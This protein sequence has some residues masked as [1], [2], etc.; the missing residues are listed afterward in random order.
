MTETN[1]DK[2]HELDQNLSKKKQKKIWRR[3][4]GERNQKVYK[5]TV[6]LTKKRES[7]GRGP[8][9][10]QKKNRTSYRKTWRWINPQKEK[11][12][13]AQNIKMTKVHEC[14]ANEVTKSSETV[15]K[16]KKNT[17]TCQSTSWK[18]RNGILGSARSSQ[19]EKGIQQKNYKED[20]NFTARKKRPREERNIQ[21][22]GRSLGTR[23]SGRGANL[24]LKPTS[25]TGHSTIRLAWG[26]I[27]NKV[28]PTQWE[29]H[30][31]ERL[32]A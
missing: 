22:G 15:W 10:D 24:N 3:G 6:K 31:G 4:R 27:Q 19:L 11:R 1:Q 16:K 2:Y 8:T 21:K 13:N 5:E 20:G 18:E 26:A 29:V 23:P 25:G 12:P 14:Q 32:G 28:Y 7:Q 30:K 17:E 9:K